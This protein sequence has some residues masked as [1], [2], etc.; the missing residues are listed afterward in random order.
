M[1]TISVCRLMTDNS[2]RCDRSSL[3]FLLIYSHITLFVNKL[4]YIL[5]TSFVNFYFSLRLL[6]LFV[7]IR[8]RQQLIK[9]CVSFHE[10]Q[11]EVQMCGDCYIVV[12]V[13]S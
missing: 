7:I 10:F 11:E 2:I 6:K 13:T 12:I 4:V 3:H 9:N 1:D 5:V 8:G